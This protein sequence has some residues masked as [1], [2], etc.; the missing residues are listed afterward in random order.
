MAKKNTLDHPKIIALADELD[1]EQAHAFGITLAVWSWAGNYASD[2]AIGRFSNRSICRGARTELRA[3][4]VIESMVKARLLD[5]VEGE[6]RLVIHDWAHHCENWVR[7]KLNEEGKTFHAGVPAKR[8]PGRPPKSLVLG[9]ENPGENPNLNS[10]KQG[11]NSEFNSNKQGV[12]SEFNSNLKGNKRAE[13]PIKNPRA[14][15]FPTSPNLSLPRGLSG[16]QDL[17]GGEMGQV[18]PEK[19]VIEPETAAEAGPK[20]GAVEPGEPPNQVQNALEA[21]AQ[22]P[23]RELSGSS[24]GDWSPPLI[25][26]PGESI[27]KGLS[28]ERRQNW[29][30]ERREIERIPTDLNGAKRAGDLA[31]KTFPNLQ[32]EDG[33]NS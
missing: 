22:T 18:V 8:G 20:L 7:D 32:I 25:V 23:E 3:D 12:N 30:A 6:A 16:N 33:G 26:R 28:A 10:N 11:V 4:K 1:I 19:P 5:E 13:N 15:P 14:R 29:M 17:I 21:A 2:G 9:T 24:G 31:R 27:P